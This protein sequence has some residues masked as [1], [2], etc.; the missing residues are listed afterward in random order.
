MK[1]GAFPNLHK[2][3]QEQI[4]LAKKIS[5][6]TEF[7]EVKFIGGVDVVHTA[8]DIICCAVVLE[9]GSRRL[10]EKRVVV[11]KPHMKYLAGFLSYRLA[12]GYVE[13]VTQLTNRPDILICGCDGIIHPRRIG[14]ASHVGLLLDMPTI[15]V[16]KKLTCGKLEDRRVYVDGELRGLAL[17]TREHAKPI[18][19][20]PGHKI[21]VAKSMEVV[22]TWLHDG[23][24]LPD[25]LRLAHKFA[26]L[27]K[28][29]LHEQE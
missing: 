28:K 15:G 6:R 26:M 5:T 2:L 29:S 23:S 20:S 7:S 10:V 4:Q 1:K 17:Q 12:P 16:A 14:C 21:S 8:K 24:K 13:A 18:F 19:V 25:P 11:T 27:E 3:K 9:A 22:S